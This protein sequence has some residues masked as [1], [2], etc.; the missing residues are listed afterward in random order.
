[1]KNALKQALI[2][3]RE[4]RIPSIRWLAMLLFAGLT[5]CVA[6]A[7]FCAPLDGIDHHFQEKG[8]ITY[9]SC[10]FL[11]MACGFAGACFFLLG[12]PW[13]SA[14]HLWLLIA[15][16]FGFF[17]VDELMQFHEKIGRFISR[18]S[19]GPTESFRNWNDVIVIGYGAVATVVLLIY[20]PVILRRPRFAE[21]LGVAFGFY[22]LHTAIDS[23]VART[24]VSVVT[25][26]TAKLFS[27][28]FFALAMFVGLLGVIAS[29]K[30]GELATVAPQQRTPSRRPSQ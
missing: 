2:Q 30:G 17:A 27:S 28:G 8:G 10:I 7:V 18:S 21:M 9:L 16:G 29:L 12:C 11:A 3:R 1:M 6:L 14:E 19:V 25:E 20:L 24:N 5:A 26:E 23:L 4:H 13:K 15:M 22:C